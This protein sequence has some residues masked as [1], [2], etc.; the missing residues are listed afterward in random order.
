MCGGCAFLWLSIQSVPSLVKASP[1]RLE[2]RFS[3]PRPGPPCPLPA[4]GTD[5]PPPPSRSMWMR[6][7]LHDRSVTVAPGAVGPPAPWIHHCCNTGRSRF[8]PT[9]RAGFGLAR[10]RPAST[11]QRGAGEVRGGGSHREL[12]GVEVDMVEDDGGRRHVVF[13]NRET[14]KCK[15]FRKV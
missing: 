8:R 1:R 13:E 9:L 2:A 15:K 14:V 3:G 6:G 11:G 4:P 7:C 12:V 5:R 10:C